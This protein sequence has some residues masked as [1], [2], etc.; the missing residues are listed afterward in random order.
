MAVEPAERLVA[1][2]LSFGGL[3]QTV[4]DMLRFLGRS[5]G[6]AVASLG[7]VEKGETRYGKEA[8][9][10]FGRGEF[11][12]TTKEDGTDREQR[13]SARRVYEAYSDRSQFV[14]ATKPGR[15]IAIL[16]ARPMPPKVS[17]GQN[18]ETK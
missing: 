16:G 11:V 18:R 13:D 9:I 6:Y 3:L 12:N 15:K 10:Q 7:Q 2:G 17:K 14:D 5:G 8:Y 4:K 1:R